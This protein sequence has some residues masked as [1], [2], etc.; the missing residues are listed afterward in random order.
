VTVRDPERAV[1]IDVG[2]DQLAV[3]LGEPLGERERLAPRFGAVDADDDAAEARH[4]V[5]GLAGADGGRMTGASHLP[6][7][8]E[9]DAVTRKRSR[10]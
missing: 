10:E 4:G 8:A 7:R 1:R 3:R 2:E 5:R 6:M 9:P